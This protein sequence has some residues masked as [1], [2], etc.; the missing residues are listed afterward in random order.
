[1]ADIPDR[2]KANFDESPGQHLILRPSRPPSSLSCRTRF[3]S[4]MGELADSGGRSRAHPHP[5]DP[6]K[7]KDQMEDRDDGVVSGLATTL[8]DSTV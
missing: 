8:C 3:A 2:G 1:M 5:P 4:A 7:N 6:E